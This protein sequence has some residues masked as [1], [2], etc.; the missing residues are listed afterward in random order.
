MK[1]RSRS[2]G[3]AHRLR[4]VV[5]FATG[6][7]VLVLASTLAACDHSGSMASSTTSSTRSTAR[8]ACATPVKRRSRAPTAPPYAA[9]GHV[10]VVGTE[11]LPTYAHNVSCTVARAVARRCRAGSCFGEFPLP[12]SGIGG[13]YGLQAPAFRPLGF[14][15]YQGVPP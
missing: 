5:V 4:P 11:R 14:Q 15:C 12:G 7:Y 9:C 6:V 2:S 8:P 13:P 10:G 3:R 1:L